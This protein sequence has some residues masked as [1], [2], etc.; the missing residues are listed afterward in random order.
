MAVGLC[1]HQGERTIRIR[2]VPKIYF[3]ITSFDSV[4]TSV[5]C[6]NI[7]MHLA[8]SSTFELHRRAWLA[9]QDTTKRP[10]DTTTTSSR[11]ATVRWSQRRSEKD[12]LRERDSSVSIV[13]AIVIVSA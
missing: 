1:G 3:V 4:L 13:I 11:A 9:E 2:T 10:L 5:C 12:I 6:R 7:S 8:H